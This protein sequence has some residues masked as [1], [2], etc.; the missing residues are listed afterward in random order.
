MKVLVVGDLILDIYHYGRSLRDSVEG[1]PAIRHDR[2]E[3]SYGGAGL[4][5]RNILRL[6]DRVIFFSLVGRDGFGRQASQFA[7]KNLRKHFIAEYQRR[8]TVKERFVVGGKKVLKWNRLD[9]RPLP[10]K[11]ERKILNYLNKILPACNKLV[12][13]D[14]RHGLISRPLATSLIRLGK[15]F[16]KPVYVDSQ[17]AQR[18]GNHRWYRGADL[19]CLNTAE[20]QS[21]DKGLDLEQISRKLKIS[22]VVVKLG[23]R[24]SKALIN[25]KIIRTPAR[26]VKAIDPTGAGDAFFAS[27][28][29]GD[30]PPSKTDLQRANSWAAL[31]TT[32][33]GTEL[34]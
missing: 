11:S 22:N 19:I 14:Y 25:G 17:L 5:V 20:A 1:L 34:P 21:I 18:T 32:M 7:H 29:L 12:I 13:S 8:T 6:G 3:V 30:F 33:L 28:A 26:R 24:G 2:T 23:A 9:D 27:L 16:R 4:L 10:H 15:K 31:T